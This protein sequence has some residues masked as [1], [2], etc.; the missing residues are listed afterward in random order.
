MHSE[1]YELTEETAEKVRACKERGGRVVAVGTT[2]AR[3]LESCWDPESGVG[4]DARVRA[5]RGATEIFIHP[6]SPPRVCDA[7]FTNFHLPKSTLIML[8]A[9]FVGTE[10]ILSLYRHAVAERFR[11]YS[12]GDAMLVER[13]A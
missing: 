8:V 9:G 13:R 12:Y 5:A 3:T 6:A 1:R 7:L 10:E 11:F 4:R 2:S